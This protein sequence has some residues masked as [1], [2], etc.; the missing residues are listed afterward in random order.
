[1]EDKGRTSY[2]VINKDSY[3][4][5]KGAFILFPERDSAARV[6]L[7]AYGEAT[8]NKNVRRFIDHWM[9]EIHDRRAM[10]NH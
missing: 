8:R 9:R 7:R 2:M 6:A 3:E 1:M 10:R 5:I 4:E